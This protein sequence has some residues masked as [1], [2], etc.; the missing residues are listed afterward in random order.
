MAVTM[1]TVFS[2]IRGRYVSKHFWTPTTGETLQTEREPDNKHNK[3]AV[4]VIRDQGKLGMY[5][6]FGTV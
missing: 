1:H 6:D 4:A 2:F 5:Q 3:F